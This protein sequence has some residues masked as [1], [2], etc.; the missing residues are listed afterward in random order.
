MIK[1]RLWD[2]L[3]DQKD[4][5]VVLVQ[6]FLSTMNL[7]WSSSSDLRIILKERALCWQNE[8]FG[9]ASFTHA[10]ALMVPIAVRSNWKIFLQ[11]LLANRELP[12]K[13]RVNLVGPLNQ[14]MT[15]IWLYFCMRTSR[16]KIL[17]NTDWAYTEP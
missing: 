12:I 1:V 9:V 6:F 17:L 8:F 11:I 16:I 2:K 15:C 14:N 13:N 3:I 5:W 7:K 10:L 4:N